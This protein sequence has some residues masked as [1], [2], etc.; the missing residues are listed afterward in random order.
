MTKTIQH[1]V[2]A[3]VLILLLGTYRDVSTEV[4]NYS[5]R[6]VNN[7][8]VKAID[9]DDYNFILKSKVKD[10]HIRN[11]ILAIIY[12]ECRYVNYSD[13]SNCGAKGC[14]QIKRV[15]VDEANRIVGFNKF[16]YED[17][18]DINKSIDI[19]ITIQSRHNPQMNPRK[20]ALIWNCHKNWYWKL[21]RRKLRDL[22]K[23]N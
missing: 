20:A 7:K 14:L 3:V 1:K 12:V 10:K 5:K 21:V 8:T 22:N 17:V 6:I 9:F 4:I 16:S 15:A 23:N 18:D 11:L 13:S 2:I 19:F